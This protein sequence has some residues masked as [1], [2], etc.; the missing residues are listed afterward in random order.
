M[1]LV[2]QGPGHLSCSGL[3]SAELLS[4]TRLRITAGDGPDAATL[5]GDLEAAVFSELST[6]GQQAPSSPPGCDPQCW[7]ETAFENNVMIFVADQSWT[8]QTDVAVRGWVASGL[9]A[10]GVVKAGDDPQVVLP[11]SLRSKVAFRYDSQIDEVAKD[12]VELLL[13]AGDDKRAFISY[14]HADGADHA[15]R[16]F[17]LLSKHQFQVYLDRFSTIKSADFVTRIADELQDKTMVVVI[18]T[19][20]SVKSPWVTHEINVA[21]RNGYGLLA[22]NIGNEP[23]HG[24]IPDSR[25]L[26]IADFPANGD[27]DATV[28]EAVQRSHLAA[29]SRLRL[30]SARSLSLALTDARNK[31]PQL[32]GVSIAADGNRCDVHTP[33]TRSYAATHAY[34]PAGLRDAR[35]VTAYGDAHS[36]RPVLVCPRP[37]RT[38]PRDDLVWLDSRSPVAVVPHGRLRYASD[39]MVRGGL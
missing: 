3:I 35:I 2:M 36:L 38:E 39:L 16:L 37:H 22:L 11:P 5:V 8:T 9:P 1:N 12:I 20:E 27:Q 24:A 4:A 13:L 31:A 30:R 7:K 26:S 25:R 29:L 17:E 15:Q 18:E 33:G 19:G 6:W 28:Y 21:K 14:A 34:R 10:A 23:K 32:Q